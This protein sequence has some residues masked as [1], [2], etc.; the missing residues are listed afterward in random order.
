MQKLKFKGMVKGEV[1][2]GCFGLTSEWIYRV[3]AYNL[4]G[5]I[6]V[7]SQLIQDKYTLQTKDY[8]FFCGIPKIN[9]EMFSAFG[10]PTNSYGK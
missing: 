3:T 8:I 4:D 7:I 10:Q 9:W 1:C 5:T 2:P 6:Y